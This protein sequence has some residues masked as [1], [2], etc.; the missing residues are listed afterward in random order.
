MIRTILFLAFA[1]AF[2]IVSIPILLIECLLDKI[3]PNTAARSSLSLIQGILKILEH[4]AGTEVVVL[5][6]ENIPKDQAV[7]YI[8][9]H[10]SYFDVILSYSRCPGLTGFI[11]KKEFANIPLLKQWMDRLNCLF[12][13]RKDTRQGL[14]MILTAIDY[15]KSGISIFIFPE[16]TRAKTDEMLPFKEGS[17]KIA[18]KSGCP[19]IPVAFTNTNAVF[20]DH[21]PFLRRARVIIHYGTPILPE[22]I[23]ADQKK[24]MGVY[25]QSIIKEML[26][27]DKK[28]L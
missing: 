22:D 12:L 20:E 27:E 11:A 9:N 1:I 16:G 3:S 23:P 17:F 19:I 25:V 26:E 18:S 2:L 6:E 15:V 24:H 7:L 5:G 21:V 8:G 10:R 14:K 13:D 28:Q 4:I